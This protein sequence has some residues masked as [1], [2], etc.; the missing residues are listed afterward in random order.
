L[1]K[2]KDVEVRFPVMDEISEIKIDVLELY[3]ASDVYSSVSLV[4]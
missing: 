3:R 1:T 2:R 4:V